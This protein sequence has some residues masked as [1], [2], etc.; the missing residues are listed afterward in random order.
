MRIA[1]SKSAHR[2]SAVRKSKPQVVRKAPSRARAIY[3]VI[4][5]EALLENVPVVVFSYRFTNVIDH[6]FIYV[7]A[8]SKALL[9]M[10][11]KE[12]MKAPNNLRLHPD[13]V[14]IFNDNVLAAMEARKSVATQV[15]VLLKSSQP[16]WVH[17]TAWPLA[18]EKNE[19]HYSGIII[20]IDAHKK[21][22]SEN[23]QTL[24]RM[25]QA[26][27]IA[28]LGW[29]DMNLKDR[30]IDLTSEFADSLGLPFAAGGRVMGEEADKYREAFL[31]AIHPDDRERYMSIISDPSCAASSSTIAS[32]R[33][34]TMCAISARGF[35]ALP[36]KTVTVF[37]ISR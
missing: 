15:R 11:P 27:D 36:I 25:E 9:G 24:A 30:V 8:Q 23:I 6:G 13:D 35:S 32:W 37:A 2:K 16:R 4:G 20:D 5:S 29:Y 34:L 33:A 10:T 26:Q 18:D 22:E 3:P 28:K 17:I 19:A 21:A 7:S 31:N 1:K 14:E 12:F